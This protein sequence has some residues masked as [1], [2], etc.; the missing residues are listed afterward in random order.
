MKT[1]NV[2]LQFGQVLRKAASSRQ[3][4]AADYFNSLGLVLPR[5]DD[6]LGTIRFEIFCVVQGLRGEHGVIAD[7]AVAEHGSGEDSASGDE[8]GCGS[9]N[10]TELR[11]IMRWEAMS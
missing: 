10:V 4:D 9:R 1:L 3:S 7:A 5:V 8:A 2:D 6:G 11:P